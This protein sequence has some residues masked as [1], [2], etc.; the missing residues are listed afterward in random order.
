M[1]FKD[2]LLKKITIDRFARQVIS[3][4]KVLDPPL[5]VDRDTMKRLLEFSPYQ[6]RRERDLDL[7]I[8][9]DVSESGKIL[10]LDNELAI[11][12]TTVEDV[13]LRKSPTIKEMINIR[14]AIKILN[15][16]DVVVSKKE[17]S[18][19]TIQ[20]ECIETLDLHFEISDIAAIEKNGVEAFEGNNPEGVLECLSLFTE[21]LDYTSV[22]KSIKVGNHYM[23]GSLTKKD[24]AQITL[25]PMIIYNITHNIIKFMGE[26]LD[27]S[28]ESQKEYLNQVIS[29]KKKAAAEGP[30]V[31]NCLKDAVTQLRL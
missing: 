6:Y 13:A 7:Y 31:F 8:K 1:P 10:V 2:N 29:G 16:S 25:G 26:P 24:D 5:K 17:D 12:N 3:S 18:I 21:L 9:S 28:D 15:D 27:I 22:P 20:R 23:A 14:N 4:L 11:Y 30:A 19:K